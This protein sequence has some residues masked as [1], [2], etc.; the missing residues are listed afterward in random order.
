[1]P[2]KAFVIP[3]IFQAI[4]KLSPTF[5]IMGKSADV[6]TA[7][8]DRIQSV[9]QKIS[10]QSGLAAAA[11]AAPLIL[12][13]KSAVDFEDRLADVA[14]TTGLEGKELSTF[15]D[16]LLDMSLKTRTSIEDLL[17]IGEI[18]GQV[19]IAKKDLVSFTDSVNKFNVALGK[20]FAGG[21]EEATSS[22][23]KMK[24][25]FKETRDLNVADSINRIGSAINVLG[26]AGNAT[27]AGITDFVLRIGA[28]PDALKPSLQNTQ[29]LGTLFEEAGVSSEIAARGFGDLVLTAAKNLPAFSKQLNLS[30]EVVQRLIETDP[31]GF[32]KKFA[33]SL[34]GLKG[35]PL[36]K[37]LQQLEIGDTGTIKVVG[38]LSTGVKRLTELQELSYKAFAD[39][40]S[41]T[42][43]YNKK[44][45]TT[46]AQ[47]AIAENNFKALSITIGTQL[48]PLINDLVAFISPVIKSIINFA[49]NNPKLTKTILAVTVALSGLLFVISAVTAVV[50]ILASPLTLI[51]LAIA[52]IIAVIAVMIIYWEDWGAA[53]TLALGPIGLIISGIQSFRNN[54]DNIKK[55]FTEGGIIDGL[56]AIGSTILDSV[57]KPMQQLLELVAKLTGFEWADKAA[58]SVQ[59]FRKDIGINM[60]PEEAKAA[61]ESK[62]AVNPKVDEQDSMTK[63][64][65]STQKTQLEMTLKAPKGTAEVTSNPW[66]IPVKLTSTQ[67]YDQ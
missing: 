32:T 20:D 55:A 64:M 51:V 47:L 58:K 46:A 6:F 44:N 37:K 29:A 57:L 19:G 26:A 67:S 54:W 33:D 36:A 35:I 62:E 61:E 48:L 52:A 43:E 50:A 12:A 34:N 42:D 53:L 1:M 7:K 31:A 14:K 41:L 66:G 24:S 30:Q 38:A 49:R 60:S 21:V 2:A 3:S 18:G 15:G 13:A 10:M 25:L 16:D 8:L 5:K 28:L 11:I 45:Q 23:G 9:S 17:K 56:L 27:S 39:G 4:D 65:E 59:A 40:T 63:R 22:V